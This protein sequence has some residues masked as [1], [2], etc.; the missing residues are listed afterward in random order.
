MQK[1]RNDCLNNR[2]RLKLRGI[3]LTDALCLLSSLLLCC[4]SS[5]M[6]NHPRYGFKCSAAV[7]NFRRFLNLRPSPAS[8]NV[9]CTNYVL[10]HGN[11]MTTARAVFEARLGAY[12]N[13]EC[14]IYIYTYSV[15]FRKIFSC[16]S[17]RI[18]HYFIFHANC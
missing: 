2:Y 9:I 13:Q 14:R 1:L 12:S 10:I 7:N 8:I 16:V 15:P 11:E 5:F 18:T 6:F 4:C 3:F 17:H